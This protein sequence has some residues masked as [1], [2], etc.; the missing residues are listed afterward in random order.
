MKEN[1][2]QKVALPARQL[3]DIV[4]KLDGMRHSRR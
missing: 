2:L 1:I 4:V 3:V